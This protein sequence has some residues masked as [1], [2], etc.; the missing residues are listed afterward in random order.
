MPQTMNRIAAP[1][2]AVAQV[3]RLAAASDRS[4]DKV[5]LSAPSFRPSR[6]R[7]CSTRT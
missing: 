3:P 6:S 1:A 7:S 4:P 5:R 2:P